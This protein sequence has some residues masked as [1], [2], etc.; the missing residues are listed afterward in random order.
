[1]AHFIE[2][3]WTNNA[4]LWG[5]DLVTRFPPE[6]NG[7]L[8][9][10]HARSVWLNASLAEKFGGRMHLRMDDTNPEKEDVEYTDSIKADIH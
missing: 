9:L 3:F 7:R 1:M 4:H 5:N 2:D 10:G 6:P 8:H